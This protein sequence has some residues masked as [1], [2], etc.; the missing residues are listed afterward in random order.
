MKRIHAAHETLHGRLAMFT[1][2]SAPTACIFF[3]TASINIFGSK[4]SHAIVVTKYL[5]K[6]KGTECL[7]PRRSSACDCTCMLIRNR[8][9]SHDSLLLVMCIVL[10]LPMPSSLTVS[11]ALS[12]ALG[13][14][15]LAFLADLTL[16]DSAAP[17]R[18]IVKLFSLANYTLLFV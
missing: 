11:D 12:Q 17:I 5:A 13:N 3:I 7:N 14:L 6:M 4:D 15:S 16:S 2:V 1:Q 9:L 18:F 8:T 10:F